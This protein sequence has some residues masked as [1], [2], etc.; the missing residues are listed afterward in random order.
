[1]SSVSPYPLSPIP[2]SQHPSI[3]SPDAPSRRL[4]LKGIYTRFALVVLAVGA[5]L[6]GYALWP[7]GREEKVEPG[8]RSVPGFNPTPPDSEH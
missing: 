5:L 1:M 2:M 6:A 3:K 4:S 7:G 8:D